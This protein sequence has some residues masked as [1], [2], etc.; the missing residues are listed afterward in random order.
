MF[1]NKNFDDISP[2]IEKI[3]YFLSSHHITTG[4]IEC[5]CLLAEEVIYVYREKKGS[6]RFSFELSEKSD[7]AVV[8]LKF[9]S[10]NY[11]VFESS[12]SIIIRNLMKKLPDCYRWEYK[13][14]YNIVRFSFATERTLWQNLRYL[15]KFIKKEK[16]RL[17][18]ACVLQLVGIAFS[19]IIPVL[20][21][22][23]I[24]NLALNALSAVVVTM[25]IL[26]LV[27]IINDLI[28]YFANRLHNAAYNQI[29]YSIEMELAN[30]IMAMQVDSIERHGTGMI[31]QR[32]TGDTISL[33]RGVETLVN[34][35]F[36]F[37]NYLGVLVAIFILSPGAFAVKFVSVLVL[38]F[39]ESLKSKREI[40]NERAYRVQND[41]FCDV[42]G[43][44]VRGNKDIKLLNSEKPF[45]EELKAVIKE[46]NKKHLQLFNVS[47]NY[48][49]FSNQIGN[50]A[51]L[52]FYFVI[53]VY[54][55]IG[56]IQPTQAIVLFNYSLNLAGVSTFIGGFLSYIKSM[57]LSSERVYQLVNKREFAKEKFG[58]EHLDNV[59]GDIEFCDV[60]FA[61]ESS[62]PMGKSN[63]VL[64]GLNLKIKAGETVAF[65]GKSGCG[66]TTA[67]NLISRLYTPTSGTVLIDG[68][69][70]SRL[71]KETI[72]GNISVVSQSPYVFNMSVKDNLRLICPDL[73]EEEMIAVCRDASIH[74]EILDFPKGY[75]TIVGEGG[76][77][78][79]G[80]QRQR[81]ALARCMLKDHRII[82]L[83]EATSAL[84]NL[85]QSHIQ[86]TINQVQNEKTV[87]IVAHR[88]STIKSCDRIFYFSE[89]RVLAQ[90]NH[91]ELME[92]CP[93]YRMLYLS[94]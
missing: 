56:Y 6:N 55:S 28:V 49:V 92:K 89:G 1:R 11:N 4:E 93:E 10:D 14:G 46:T 85:T 20:S 65:V 25:L 2:I 68:V 51:E 26:F 27:R 70:I 75:D 61:Y 59:A 30:A 88:L 22:R 86:N 39:I 37:I 23:L 91:E 9:K 67:L 45:M 19:V 38:I 84:D 69:D 78:M 21:A 58:E 53:V 73:S 42:V 50:I 77:M 17:S 18:G 40:N 94:E 66:K 57:G 72:R 63:E 8:S 5:C 32:M 52:C 87:V 29:R 64:T 33:A 43:E 83:D 62:D 74:D 90:G 48:T 76:V 7:K 3:E 71:D 15:G 36:T 24:S 81:L 12:D 35:S 54:L 34:R 13:N 82:L 41:R 47:Q 16:N 80:G 79:S 60:K 31:I 44:M